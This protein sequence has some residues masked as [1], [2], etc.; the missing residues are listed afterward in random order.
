[1]ENNTQSQAE[2]F[3]RI[4]VVGVGGAGCNAINRMIAEGIQ[5]IEFVAVNTDGQAL[6]QSSA[7]TRV[8]IGDKITRGLGAGGVPEM[9]KKAA[10]ESADEL[11]AVLKGSDMI[12]VTAGMGGGTGTGAAPII[13]QIGKEV[14]ALAIGVVTRPFMFEGSHRM[15]SAEAGIQNL[16]KVADTLIVIP[17]DRLLQ[18]VDK[19]ASLKDAFR[20]ADDVLR[21]GVQGI[22]ELITVPGLINLDFADIRTIMSEGGAALMAVGQASG[23][24]RATKAA[25]MAISSE[26]LDITIDG[27]HGIL[28]N[29]T[30]GESLTLFEVNQ[31]A[32]IIKE[33]AHPDVNLIFG[34]VIDPSMGDD[35]RLT[36][37][38]TGFDSTSMHA[39]SQRTR[40]TSALNSGSR[41][42]NQSENTETP[43]RRSLAEFGSQL[44][45][46]DEI[47]VPA[48]LRSLQ[49]KN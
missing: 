3:A 34:A 5:G 10:E 48:F 47:E 16:K 43:V 18:I 36:V 27:A 44:Y 37:I 31:A 12:F 8:R 49:N 40:F 23:E 4:K 35:I 41:E 17:N 30:G 6:L 33:T 1:M 20:V 29:V 9:G 2:T 26:L 14:G 21:Q 15:Q 13:T 42:A 46:T 39:R 22:S 24:D 38:A 28:F 32:A 7:Q 19:R 11:Y 25:E 45:N